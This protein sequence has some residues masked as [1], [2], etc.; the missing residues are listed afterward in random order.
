VR[1]GVPEPDFH[2][3]EDVTGA[4]DEEQLHGEVVQRNPGPQQV[5]V[6]SDEYNDIQSL[7]FERDA[8][9]GSLVQSENTPETWREASEADL[10]M[11]GLPVFSGVR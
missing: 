8:W 4:A 9:P 2:E 6:A 7:R 1:V 3:I 11:S 10:Y 5:Q